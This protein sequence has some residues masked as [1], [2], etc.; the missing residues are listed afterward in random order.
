MT[1]QGQKK[2]TKSWQVGNGALH[3][4]HGLRDLV[5]GRSPC[6]CTVA[7]PLV[8]PFEYD[9]PFS[10]DVSSSS[11]PRGSSSRSKRTPSSPSKPAGDR[12]LLPYSP[13]HGVLRTKDDP[14]LELSIPHTG[15]HEAGSTLTPGDANFL[16]RRLIKLQREVRDQSLRAVDLEREARMAREAEAAALKLRA[17]A[18]TKYGD[19]DRHVAER[20]RWQA[21]EAELERRWEA[22]LQAAQAEARAEARAEAEAA[23]SSLQPG[24]I[25]ITTLAVSKRATESESGA[26]T[27]PK[28]DWTRVGNQL[29]FHPRRADSVQVTPGSPQNILSLFR[30]EKMRKNAAHTEPE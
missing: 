30:P 20:A 13:F 15:A 24:E 3:P 27:A 23:F 10:T 8:V 22:R 9:L 19:E 4:H 1:W 18:L 2:S 11:S 7:T 12:S 29:Y 21:R 16:R 5:V 25:N 17:E 14:D 6:G 28:Q 26:R